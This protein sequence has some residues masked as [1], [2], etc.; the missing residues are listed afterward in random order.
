M[1]RAILCGVQNDT[2]RV[3]A[4]VVHGSLPA[5][6]HTRAEHDSRY[7]CTRLA[8][9]LPNTHTHTVWYAGARRPLS[10]DDSASRSHAFDEISCPRG[11]RC[12]VAAV[13][14]GP[15]CPFSRSAAALKHRINVNGATSAAGF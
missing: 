14:Q 15:I 13:R 11:L 3:C 4:R 12:P 6:I 10:Q 1:P 8:Y 7:R 5:H 2:A 9:A